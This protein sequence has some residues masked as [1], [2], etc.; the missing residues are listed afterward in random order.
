MGIPS[1]QGLWDNITNLVGRGVIVLGGAVFILISFYLLFKD[2]V[3]NLVEKGR[4]L[5]G[6]T[7]DKT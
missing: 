7:D 2:N 1:P 5:G 3:D 4:N 6:N